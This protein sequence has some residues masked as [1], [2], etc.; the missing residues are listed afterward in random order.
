MGSSIVSGGSA[1][2]VDGTGHR[3]QGDFRVFSILALF[4]WADDRAGDG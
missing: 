3:L 1:G 2:F 4:S